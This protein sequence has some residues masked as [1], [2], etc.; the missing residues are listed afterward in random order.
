VTPTPGRRVAVV[1]VL[2]AFIAGTVALDR[3]RND[4]ES[5]VAAVQPGAAGS[6]SS[7]WYCPGGTANG[8]AAELTVA[9]MNPGTERLTGSVTVVPSGA[10]QVVRPLDVGPLAAV[11]IAVPTLVN[12][13]WA[14]VL[15]DLDGGGA[16]VEQMVGG[17]LDF[18]VAPCSP[19]ASAEWYFAAGSTAK[20]VSLTLALFNPFPDD[21]IVDLAFATNEGRRVPGDFQ[22]IVVGAGTVANVDIGS[23]LRRQDFVSTEVKAR[24]GRVIAGQVEVH[25][26]PPGA[27]GV[28]SA[29][30]APSLGDTWYFPDG[31]VADGVVERFEL[32]NPGAR[33]ARVDLELALE[34]GEAEPFELTIPPQ[35]RL[36]FNAGEQ[37]ER[38]PKAVAHAVVARSIEGV[39]FVIQR[40]V[41]SRAPRVG[42]ADTMGARRTARRWGFAI[43]S[44]STALDQ[45]MIV[46]NTT[47]GPATVSFLALAD[48]QRIA[49]E[50]LQRIIVPAGRRMAFRLSDHIKR[51]ALPLVVESSSPVVVERALYLSGSPGLASSLGIPLD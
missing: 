2:L 35:G 9:V 5:Q 29:L 10:T 21:A 20:D 44:V 11:Q 16:V 30:G 27:A 32:Y 15:I 40:V 42:R 50:G 13:P 43:G 26:G 24:A 49:I 6:L 23:H 33:E 28:S 8:G 18:D 19:V 12:A 17:P 36:T 37:Q 39:P 7:S 31:L 47:A 41:E 14:A 4:D 1:L 45:W 46:Q 51:D 3:T 25:P 34:Q 48:G 22:G 38:I